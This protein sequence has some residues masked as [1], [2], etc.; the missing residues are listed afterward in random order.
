MSGLNGGYY[1]GNESKIQNEI[2]ALEGKKRTLLEQIEKYS[3]LLALHPSEATARVLAEREQQVR[4]VDSSIG[5]KSEMLNHS[6]VTDWE[7][8]TS[9]ID[10]KSY[11]GRLRANSLIKRLGIV[12]TFA[13]QRGDPEFDYPLD[14]ILHVTRKEQIDDNEAG[15]WLLHS[16]YQ[17]FPEYHMLGEEYIERAKHYG[18]FEP[19][20]DR[21]SRNLDHKKE[22]R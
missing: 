22:E 2:E 19:T 21:L 13:S 15:F 8:F 3:E 11:E 18:F 12:F 4:A 1:K 16:K 17:D 5:E 14:V 7:A 9:S 20:F 10:L 6:F